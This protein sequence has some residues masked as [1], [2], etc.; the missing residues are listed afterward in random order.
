LP[1]NYTSFKGG[2]IF[3]YNI[4][5]DKWTSESAVQPT[6]GNSVTDSFCCGSF[7]YNAAARKAYF[8]SGTNGAGAR[9]NQPFTAP[10]YVGVTNEETFGN[11]NFLTFDT[12]AFR[13]KN[14]TMNKQLTTTGTE[15]GQFVFL[16]G[17]SSSTGGLGVQ[18]GGRRRDTKQMETMR[19]VLVYDS[20][21]D[22]WYSQATTVEGGGDFPNGRRWF[23]AVAASAP[24]NSSHSIYMY[25]GESPNSA[26]DAHSDMWILSVPSFTWVRVNVDSPPRKS[27][28]CTVVGHSYMVTYGGVPSGGTK[29]EGDDDPCDQE[30]YGL[31]LF[32]MSKLAWTGRYGGPPAAGRNAYTVP[33]VVYNAIGG[34][35]QGSATR[36]APSGGF[37]TPDLASLFQRFAPAGT[38]PASSTST[39]SDQPTKKKPNVGAIAGGVIGGL[40]GLAV[41]LL[42]ALWLLKRKRVQ[43]DV[44][45]SPTSPYEVHGQYMYPRELPGQSSG[46]E[47]KSHEIYTR[48]SMMPQE[49][50]AGY[51]SPAPATANIHSRA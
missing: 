17:T 43:S 32:D 47:D 49:M 16:P 31:R 50:Y 38:V 27:L 13:W 41:I 29:E 22:T 18:I 14:A 42:G 19:K 23:C 3:T 4:E 2:S 26:E 51:T 46:Q 33:K 48:E 10:G 39:D 21:N 5:A 34:N 12:A 36:T 8:Y 20:A 25:G 37:E 40:A 11:S 6:D 30:N 24:D 35:E 1:T 45:S 44:V 15:D 9:R 28:G 7:A